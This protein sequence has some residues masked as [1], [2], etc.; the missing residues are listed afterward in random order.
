[1]HLFHNCQAHMNLVCVG[2]V[3]TDTALSC[4]VDQ[5]QLAFKAVLNKAQLSN[6]CDNLLLIQTWI[7][8]K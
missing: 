4:L 1:M 5:I 3:N 7:G 8:L 2:L 6:S